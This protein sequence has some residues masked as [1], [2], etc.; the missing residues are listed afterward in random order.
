MKKLL[1]LLLFVPLVSCSSDDEETFCIDLSL[2][3]NCSGAEYIKNSDSSYVLP[4][5]IGKTFRIGQGNCTNGSHS[6]GSYS[7]FAYDIS[8][9]IGTNIHA[10]Q[11]GVV[12]RVVENFDDVED[13]VNDVS[14]I[15]EANFI[16]I[17]HSDGTI[18]SYVHLTKNGALKKEGDIVIQGESIALSGNSGWSSGP[19]LHFQLNK[20]IDT[21]PRENYTWYSCNSIPLTFKNTSEHC[22]GLLD[23]NFKPEGYTANSF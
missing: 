11:S 12:L 13:G 7:Q 1:F 16:E 9:P 15:D 20:C 17:E 5:E 6:E 10:I 3:V 21:D 23:Y 22:F 4:W 8:M 2:G 14:L 18:A 19:H